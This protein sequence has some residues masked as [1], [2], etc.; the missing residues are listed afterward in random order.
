MKN[1]SDPTASIWNVE[2]RVGG[3]TS[4]FLA[5][6]DGEKKIA[7][8][9]RHNPKDNSFEVLPYI[10]LELDYTVHDDCDHENDFCLLEDDPEMCWKMMDNNAMR[11]AFENLER[12]EHQLRQSK[13]AERLLK[14]KEY[15]E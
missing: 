6:L 1:Y 7:C 14:E 15:R 2:R 4:Y 9:L 8:E 11:L 10:P 5:I 13:V 3:P 12:A